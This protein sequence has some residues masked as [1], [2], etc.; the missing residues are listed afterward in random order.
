MA[1][2][3]ENEANNVLHKGNKAMKSEKI[4]DRTDSVPVQN[5]WSA[6]MD[7]WVLDIR[8]CMLHF[9]LDQIYS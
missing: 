8:V 7:G 1:C 3:L 2:S 9:I 4:Q 6:Q 5:Q